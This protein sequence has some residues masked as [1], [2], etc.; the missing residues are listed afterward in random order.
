[1]TGGGG[2]RGGCRRWEAAGD[3]ALNA[4]RQSQTRRSGRRCPSGRRG[5]FSTACGQFGGVFHT[6][7]LVSSTC[8]ENSVSPVLRKAAVRLRFGGPLRLVGSFAST[9]RRLSAKAKRPSWALRASAAPSPQRPHSRRFSRRGFYG[10]LAEPNLCR[11]RRG[12]SFQPPA[13]RPETPGLVWKGG[14]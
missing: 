9:G 1:M 3:R 13:G 11:R 5:I 8:V 4:T 12:E 14:G 7:G 10:A 6:C 2:R